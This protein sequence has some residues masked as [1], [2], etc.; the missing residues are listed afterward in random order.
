[1]PSCSFPPPNYSYSLHTGVE[2]TFLLSHRA[3]RWHYNA[4]G[5]NRALSDTRANACEIVAWRFIARQSERDAV[6]YCL[7]E[8]PGKEA[9]NA[10]PVL[11]SNI[12]PDGS[13]DM[14]ANERSP[15]LAGPM[16]QQDMNAGMASMRAELESALPKLTLS[17]DSAG[18]DIRS[19][20][21]DRSNSFKN[22]NALEIAVIASAKRFL[23]QHIVQK[24]ITSMWHGEIIFW[25]QVSVYATK[26]PRYYNLR[27]ADPY[28]RLRVPK[29]LKAWEMAFFIIFLVLYYSVVLRRSYTHIPVVEIVF[30]F[31]LASFAWDE[32]LEWWDAG[33]FYMSDIWNIFDMS[34]IT[35][36][37]CFAVLRMFSFPPSDLHMTNL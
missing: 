11:H 14:E 27:T 20:I 17:V 12:G 4:D 34:M 7:H 22:L 3:L 23:S 18:D 9:L 13:Y 25:D 36:G 2:L 15:L 33:V 29:Y 31:W 8:I 16:T 32:F 35:I 10:A 30:Y 26:K 19:G 21:K 24:I 37:V 6:S 5:D 1:M 28:S